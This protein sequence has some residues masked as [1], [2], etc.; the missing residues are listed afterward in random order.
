[1]S[2]Q[3]RQA[4]FVDVVF[5]GPPGPEGGRFVEVED[6]AGRSIDCGEWITS[7]AG[8][9]ALRIPLHPAPPVREGA[10]LAAALVIAVMVLVCAGIGFGLG[11]VI[12]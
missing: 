2:A 1:M 4:A 8:M 11:A 10:G 9:W 7:G 5:D 3:E 6:P 12:V